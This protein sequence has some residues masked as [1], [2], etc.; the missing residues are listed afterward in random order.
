M[1]RSVVMVQLVAVEPRAHLLRRR[2]NRCADRRRTRLSHWRNAAAGWSR[3]R[4]FTVEH[5]PGRCAAGLADQVVVPIRPGRGTKRPCKHRCGSRAARERHRGRR[6]TTDPSERHPR[7]RVLTGST[8]RRRSVSSGYRRSQAPRAIM[9]SAARVHALCDH[10]ETHAQP[11]LDSGGRGHGPDLGPPD[12][13]ISTGDTLT[14][15]R[16]CYGGTNQSVPTSPQDRASAR[17]KGRSTWWDV[18]KPPARDRPDAALVGLDPS[19]RVHARRGSNRAQ[20]IA[21]L[22]VIITQLQAQGDLRPT[23]RG[24]RR[25]SE[26]DPRKCADERIRFTDAAARRRLR[27]ATAI[28]SPASWSRRRCTPRAALD[29]PDLVADGPGSRSPT[30][31][32]RSGAVSRGA[33]PAAP[34]ARRLWGVRRGLAGAVRPDGA[35]PRVETDAAG[36]MR[37][38]ILWLG[39]VTY[40]AFR[41]LEHSVRTGQPAFEQVFGASLFDYMRANPDQGAKFDAAMA[42][43]S[44]G[45]VAG[46]FDRDWSD[47]ATV[48]DVGGG[49]ATIMRE[50]LAC[51]PQRTR[52]GVRPTPSG[53]R[54]GSHDR[55]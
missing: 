24:R 35:L 43:T 29:V 7:C 27:S 49:N 51:E 54:S 31:R 22:P 20:T 39:E 36:S 41:E 37:P 21:A 38:Y 8:S 40:S 18:R 9:R 6:S 50:L 23:S 3:D 46:L 25:D 34:D 10:T 26:H 2:T 4:A 55:G 15:T 33:G 12:F 48:I 19:Y 17:S 13:L 11:L 42:A 30:W 52:R 45:R 32:K 53:R 16:R 5:E 44:V 28:S 14:F 1:D 47:A